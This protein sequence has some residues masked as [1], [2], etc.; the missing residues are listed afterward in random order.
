[1]DSGRITLTEEKETLL[2]TLFAKAGESHLSDSL[3]KDTFAAEAVQRIDYDFARFKVTHDLK[4]GLAMRA[5]TLDGWVRTFISANPDA[6]VL[7]LGCGLD[8]RVFRVDPPPRVRWFDVDYPEVVAL[9]RRLYPDRE[10]YA[11]IGSSVVEAAWMDQLPTDR[12]TMI[13]AE[14]LLAY[15]RK[16]EVQQLFTALAARVPRGEAAFDAFSRLGVWVVQR[17]HSVRATG[18][19]LRWSIEDPRELEQMVPRL[20][21]FEEV[22]A[23]DPAQLRRFSLPARLTVPVMLAIPAIR[24]LGRFLRYR[25]E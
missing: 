19:T 3:L 5:W 25:F 2:I 12:P 9:R 8:T 1:M 24:R 10:G 6:C 15:L 16:E 21:F 4:V 7:H 11:L 23:Y 20:K 17:Q 22:A 14:G 18:A 13:V